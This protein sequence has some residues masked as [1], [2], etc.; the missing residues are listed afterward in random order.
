MSYD[1]PAILEELVAKA[2]ARKSKAQEPKFSAMEL[3]KVF[4]EHVPAKCLTYLV[5]DAINESE[6]STELET[7]CYR[8]AATCPKLRII[9]SSTSDWSL[10]TDPSVIRFDAQ[11][12][13]RDVDNDIRVYIDR[14][15]KF[16]KTLG[17]LSESLKEEI[18]DVVLSKSNGI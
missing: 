3:E 11:M 4:V 16:D 7:L 17:M 6:I 2:E 14:R 9:I 15:L 8:L 5:L 13:S 12:N 1:V 10:N 18:R